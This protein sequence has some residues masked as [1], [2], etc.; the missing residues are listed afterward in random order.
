[1]IS[2]HRHRVFVTVNT[3]RQWYNLMHECRVWFGQDWRSQPHVRKKFKKFGN[4][5]VEVWF[6]V[7][8]I[9]WC[10]WVAV[11]LGTQVNSVVETNK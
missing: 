11:K 2:K 10:S 7:P 5:P 3:E 1:M 4:T 9:N 6:E 8:N